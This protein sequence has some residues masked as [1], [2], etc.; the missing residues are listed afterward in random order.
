[1]FAKIKNR[2]L[3]IWRVYNYPDMNNCLE[4][5]SLIQGNADVWQTEMAK[6]EHSILG[7]QYLVLVLLRDFERKPHT[8]VKMGA[9]RSAPWR[10]KK[11]GIR[12]VLPNHP[13]LCQSRAQTSLLTCFSSICA[14]RCKDKMNILQRKKSVLLLILCCLSTCVRWLCCDA[15]NEKMTGCS[16]LS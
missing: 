2:W 16:S 4:A 15:E 12:E 3:K 6:V 14:Y 9:Y 10:A 11:S 1:M 7:E 13:Q 5:K 8:D